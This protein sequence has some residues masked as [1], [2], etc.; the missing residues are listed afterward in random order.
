MEAN[1]K[2]KLIKKSN[3]VNRNVKK[4]LGRPF[5]SKNKKKKYSNNTKITVQGLND[6]ELKW[7]QHDLITLDEHDPL[8][9]NKLKP[10]INILNH[11][12]RHE[13]KAPAHYSKGKYTPWE[14]IL[15]WKLDYFTGNAIKY[16]CRHQHK[17]KPAEDIQKAIDC[18]VAYKKELER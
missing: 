18:L 17:G 11:A 6:D 8:E 4:K 9:F 13:D 10:A 3:K 2:K 7:P 12:L 16:I 14:I 5:G 15:D 1:M